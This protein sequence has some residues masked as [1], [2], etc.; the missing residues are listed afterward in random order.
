MAHSW[1]LALY[2]SLKVATSGE[3]QPLDC[4]E[5]SRNTPS[6]QITSVLCEIQT[7]HSLVLRKTLQNHLL[8]ADSSCPPYLLSNL[9]K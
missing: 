4:R 6:T 5:D 1:N 2:P 8:N 3:L 7:S 9:S